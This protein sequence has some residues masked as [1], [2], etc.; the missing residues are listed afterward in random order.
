MVYS[1]AKYDIKKKITIFMFMYLICHKID[2]FCNI[3]TI[4]R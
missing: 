3:D 2:K 1:N 4:D